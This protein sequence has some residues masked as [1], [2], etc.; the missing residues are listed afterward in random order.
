MVSVEINYHYLGIYEDGSYGPVPITYN[1]RCHQVIE[2][3]GRT[4][5][6]DDVYV[7][8]WEFCRRHSTEISD[9]INM[10]R[11]GNE[12]PEI[13]EEV[14]RIITEV[15]PNDHYNKMSKEEYKATKEKEWD[16]RRE[17]AE[18]EGITVE[19]WRKRELRDKEKY[20]KNRKRKIY[21]NRTEERRERE[22]HKRAWEAYDLYQKHPEIFSGP[23][24]PPTVITRWVGTLE[25]FE[26][27]L[28]SNT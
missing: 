24:L 14:Q 25:E 3:D 26:E 19:E 6:G 21:K 7:K 20:Y 22:R 4:L 10:Y 17:M 1:C 18:K 27:Q 23:V 12:D 16:M 13:R 2:H 28:K 9:A 11:E 15:I 5:R 8:K